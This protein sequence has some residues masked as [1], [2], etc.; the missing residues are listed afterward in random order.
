MSTKEQMIEIPVR[1]FSSLAMFL[2]NC[3]AGDT[4]HMLNELE[5]IGKSY[6]APQPAKV[7]DACQQMPEL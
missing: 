6:S 7:Q 3:R 2:D 5:A 4:R 1:L